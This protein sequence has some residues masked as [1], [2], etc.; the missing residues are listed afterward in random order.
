[1][2]IITIIV[3]TNILVYTVISTNY[4]IYSF[5]YNVSE[6][7]YYFFLLKYFNSIKKTPHRNKLINLPLYSYSK[8]YE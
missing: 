1:M 4:M 6:K 3:C 7:L 5:L 8:V 2:F